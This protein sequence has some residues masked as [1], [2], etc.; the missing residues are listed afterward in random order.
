MFRLTQR[1]HVALAVLFVVS[2]AF[3]AWGQE[4]EANKSMPAVW[5]GKQVPPADLD[6]ILKEHKLWLDAQEKQGSRA[7]LSGALLNKADLS[8]AILR[9]ADLSGP[10]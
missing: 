7:N 6:R 2:A 1:W 3:E 10:K 9:E 4:E 5:S 8:R